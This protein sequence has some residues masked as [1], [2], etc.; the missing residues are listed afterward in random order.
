MTSRAF[1][2]PAA[3]GQPG[4]RGRR[5]TGKCPQCL[6]TPCPGCPEP[7]HNT[8]HHLRKRP[9]SCEFSAV[10]AV[11][12]CPAVCHLVA[13]RA[14]ASRC[15]RTHSGRDLCP[16]TVGAH[17]RLFYG[18]PRTGRGGSAFP[19][20]TKMAAAF[21]SYR[22]FVIGSTTI[23]GI[24]GRVWVPEK[25]SPHATCEYSWIRPRAGRGAGPGRLRPERADA[26]ARQAGA[27]PGAADACCNDRRTQRGLAEGAARR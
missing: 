18:R 22:G 19:R 8:C 17:R 20:V 6:E 10:R 25:V 27:V 2:I 23:C 13:L 4:H 15:P 11:F 24:S 7:R 3:S 5:R 26:D 9:V 21:S 16:G 14:A 1:D 12:L